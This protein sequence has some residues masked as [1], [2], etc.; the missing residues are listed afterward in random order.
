[1][2]RVWPVVVGVARCGYL[3]LAGAVQDVYKCSGE[4]LF[5]SQ[6]NGGFQRV[7]E[8]QVV[9]ADVLGELFVL[10]HRQDNDAL[11]TSFDPHRWHRRLT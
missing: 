11:I 1:M 2:M 9:G 4:L 3:G 6:A 8:Q 10:L 7:A 5:G